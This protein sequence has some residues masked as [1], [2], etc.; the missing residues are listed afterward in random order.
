VTAEAPTPTTAATP[1]RRV[2]RQARFEAAGL[3]RHGEQLLVSV[4]LP[5]LALLVLALTDV[6]SLGPGRRID[7]ATAGVLALAVV[8]TAFTGQAI[9]L[10]FERRH[11]VLR[12]LGTTPLGR[13][14]LLAAKGASVL[15]VLAVQVVVLG[16]LGLAL[17]WRP[18]PAGVVPALALMLLGVAAFAS[19]AVLLGGTLRAEGVLA[20]ANLGWVLFLGLGGVVIPTSQLP[21]G[22]A[23]VV[24]WLPSA[25]LG[26]GLRA[27]LTEG[28]LPL[29]E[30]L[31]LLL[32]AAVVGGL[33]TRLLRWSD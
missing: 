9:L 19:L 4:V 8:S 28:A 1:S 31:V 30:A 27:A 25:A 32:W 24:V 5:A 12:L 3:L 26:D 7:L 17:G 29:R 14:G 21:E 10:A 23:A 33:A 20:L 18:D 13:G 22:L 2:L 6:P 16:G 11:G 15:V